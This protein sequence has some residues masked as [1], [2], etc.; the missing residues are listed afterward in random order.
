MTK[1]HN[2][3]IQ[4]ALLAAGNLRSTADRLQQA[5]ER[6]DF[7]ALAEISMSMSGWDLGMIR[8]AALVVARQNAELAE[9]N[10]LSPPAVLEDVD[11]EPFDR[12]KR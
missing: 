4:A 10:R 8:G 7:E 2:S 3:I 12:G 6:R 11:H 5:A 9:R 1:T